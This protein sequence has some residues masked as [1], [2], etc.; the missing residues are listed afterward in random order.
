MGRH[1]PRLSGPRSTPRKTPPQRTKD[2]EQGHMTAEIDLAELREIVEDGALLQPREALALIDTVEA[3]R[4]FLNVASDSY[5]P[6]QID[7]ELRLA[8]TL[9]RFITR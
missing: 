6:T 8:E 5:G 7:A 3:A 4:I 1:H 9:D 2:L